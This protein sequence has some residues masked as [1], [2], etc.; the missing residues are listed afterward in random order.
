M[1]KKL[2][3]STKT[4][5]DLPAALATAV[6][7][8]GWRVE[9]LTLRSGRRSF[10]CW[11]ERSPEVRGDRLEGALAVAVLRARAEVAGSTTHP[12]PLAV[13]SAPRVSQRLEARLVEFMQES[14][15]GVGWGI[16]DDAGRVVVR[17]S[18]LSIDQP[19]G[20]K[21]RVPQASVSGELFTDL[22]QWVLKVLLSDLFPRSQLWRPEG[23]PYRNASV[24]AEAADVSLPV[25]TRLL[26]RL[27]TEGFVDPRRASIELVRV[28]ELL[29][30]WRAALARG[31]RLQYR[32][33]LKDSALTSARWMLEQR[34]SDPSLDLV[35]GLFDA[36]EHLGQR[37]VANAPHIVYLRRR[38]GPP[39]DQK[40]LHDIDAI[41]VGAQEPFDLIIRVPRFPE[42]LFR[43]ALH[44]PDPDLGDQL[45][46]HFTDVLQTW[47]DVS[48]HA[49]RGAELGERLW[50]DL[51]APCL[52]EHD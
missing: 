42:A 32:V 13:V 39:V 34:F 20:F 49:A 35:F 47:M 41:P 50:R 29:G 44:Q 45:V 36:A 4:S 33:R 24:L 1:S 15:G 22:N 21:P 3:L 46:Y 12:E 6:K 31:V 27:R 11:V 43:G 38:D 52:S 18:G 7:R 5:P 25:A 30:R 8:S 51:I 2:L 23:A 16:A 28:S 10:L 14:G 40:L 37:H 19:A 48:H 17:S 9:G 26:H